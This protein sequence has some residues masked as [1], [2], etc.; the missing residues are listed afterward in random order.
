MGQVLLGYDTVLHRQVAIKLISADAPD[1]AAL[2]RFLLEA[3]AIARVQHRNVLQIYRVGTLGG[4]PYLVCEFLSGCSLAERPCP[5][6]WREALA[7]GIGLARGL[8]AVHAEGILH[9]DIKPANAVLLEDGEVK[10][11]D[12][13]LAKVPASADSKLE[14]DGASAE[15]PLDL[16]GSGM[17]VGT[18]LY[19]A[20]EL[21]RGAPATTRSDVYALGALLYK[22][23]TGRTP[24]AAPTLA[25]L[26]EA[27]LAGEA[28]PPRTLIPQIEP[29]FDAVIAR[30]LRQTPT[31]RFASGH[32]VYLAL[33]GLDGSRQRRRLLL[34]LG[35]A[36]P[37]TIGA[38]G[39][40]IF[41]TMTTSPALVEPYQLNGENAGA[42]LRHWNGLAWTST[43][44]PARHAVW[45]LW[46]RSKDDIWAVGARG[47]ALHWDGVRWTLLDCGTNLDLIAVWGT[48]RGPAS[49]TW[50]VGE[51]GLILRFRESQRERVPSGTQAT[52]FDLWGSAS[53]D[54][55][56]VGDGGT[57][58]HWDGMGWRQV[59][60]GTQ[61]S[62]ISVWGTGEEVWAV[63]WGGTILHRSGRRN[64]K[65]WMAADSGSQEKLW[66]LWGSSST[67]VWASGSHGTLLHWDGAAWRAAASGTSAHL[68]AVWGVG[69][70]AVW[71]GGAGGILL[72]WNGEQWSRVVGM[73]HGYLLG[74][75]GSGLDDLWTAG[76][77]IPATL[78]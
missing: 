56:S 51:Q 2:Q 69:P 40:A 53:D 36:G 1:P 32:E 58:L 60:S 61:Y 9:R 7:I 5:M 67:D 17:W 34:G 42:S 48:P 26:R 27:V 39:L 6:V 8:A 12:F 11:V 76:P 50:I 18:P 10:L 64:M 24:H 47:T 3:R 54:V 20:P 25:A 78:Y 23:C 59:P 57:M 43:P 77:E 72:R 28:P 68:A 31:E 14:P 74:L 46:G 49:T 38:L 52:L 15:P 29:R 62:L 45:D 22:L 75:W 66:S 30:C 4:R 21:F 16:T 71:A 33:S 63:G 41:R 37:L 70:D 73:P 55:W 44:S 19:M 65:G 35:F 13:G